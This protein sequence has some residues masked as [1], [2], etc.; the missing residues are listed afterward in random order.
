MITKDSNELAKIHE[1]ISSLSGVKHVCP[2]IILEVLK[3]DL[4]IF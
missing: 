1:E 4:T 2:A 3:E